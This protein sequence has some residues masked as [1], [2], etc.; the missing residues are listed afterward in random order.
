MRERHADHIG[1]PHENPDVVE[2]RTI[3]HDTAGFQ[4]S[5]TCGRF[6]DCVLAFGDDQETI[7]GCQEHIGRRNNILAAFA[8]HRR[9]H[10]AWHILT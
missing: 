10:A 5:Q 8:D 7:S 6:G 2:G 1:L 3:F 9:L 4:P